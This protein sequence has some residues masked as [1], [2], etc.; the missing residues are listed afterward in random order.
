MKGEIDKFSLILRSKR[1]HGYLS[2]KM[3]SAM[4]TQYAS[5]PP[6]QMRWPKLRWAVRRSLPGRPTRSSCLIVLIYY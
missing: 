2:R 6:M 3:K 1:S 4:S 5:R